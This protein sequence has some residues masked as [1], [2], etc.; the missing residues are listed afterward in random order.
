MSS[1]EAGL[2]SCRTE[3]LKLRAAGEF[4]AAVALLEEALLTSVDVNGPD[5]L[6]TLRIRNEIG[7]TYELA[8]ELTQA[9]A[10]LEANLAVGRRVL[11]P[12]NREVL[13]LH[14]NLANVYL[15]AGMF[16]RATRMWEESLAAHELQC[17]PNDP[18]F[19]DGPSE[20]RH[21]VPAG[22]PDRAGHGALRR[23]SCRL[24]AL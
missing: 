20:T 22:G 21:R 6:P 19:V 17:L 9:I 1:S 5:S 14:H 23:D 3:A 10:V 13:A 8:G 4:A 24:S 7:Y 2:E 15:S 12:E 18:T 11:G 16:D